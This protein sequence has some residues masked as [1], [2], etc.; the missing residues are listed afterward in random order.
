LKHF[1]GTLRKHVIAFQFRLKETDK[2]L[3]RRV[4]S[5]SLK[6]MEESLVFRLEEVSFV[7]PKELGTFTILLQAEAHGFSPS[8]ISGCPWNVHTL[9]RSYLN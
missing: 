5:D 8:P 4:D 7:V 1:F 9:G 3:G 6:S 2:Y